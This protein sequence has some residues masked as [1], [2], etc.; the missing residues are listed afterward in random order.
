[1]QTATSPL[2]FHVWDM[3]QKPFTLPE[4]IIQKY[5]EFIIS[6]HDPRA[7]QIGAFTFDDITLINVSEHEYISGREARQKI[8][9]QYV[10]LDAYCA[11]ALFKN[12]GAMKELSNMWCRRYLWI[13]SPY[14]LRTINFFGSM[15][16]YADAV[17]K[18][19]CIASFSY[20][21]SLSAIGKV[22]F[23]P[24][25]ADDVGWGSKQDFALVFTEKFAT[26]HGLI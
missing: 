23:L 11:A 21:Y 3:R 15:L 7:A 1:M 5:G 18:R 8:L 26:E 24:F 4:E 16:Q 20:D 25:E 12:K 2:V 14:S 19:D 17:I 10:P 9:K 22:S 6:E 13:R